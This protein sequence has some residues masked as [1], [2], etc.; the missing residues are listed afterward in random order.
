MARRKPAKHTQPPNRGNPR[1][2]SGVSL[3][4]ALDRCKRREMERYGVSG[5]WVSALAHALLF[6]IDIPYEADYRNEPWNDRK[7]PRPVLRW[8][9]R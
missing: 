5:S 4:P 8:K 9:R 2:P 1:I 7:R 3:L 6:K